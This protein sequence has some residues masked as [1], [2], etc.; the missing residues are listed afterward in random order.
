MKKSKFF[1]IESI[2]TWINL[3]HVEVVYQARGWHVTMQN[4]SKF[5]LSDAEYE[6][7]SERLQ[8]SEEEKA[9]RKT[10]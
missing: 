5:R 2:Q 10:D 6:A 7:L 4:G 9:E 1:Y 8:A 3:I